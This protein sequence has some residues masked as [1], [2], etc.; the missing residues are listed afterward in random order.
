M[1]AFSH[2]LCTVRSDK[3]SRAA[4]SA[5]ENP[6]KNLHVYQFSKLRVDFGE[7]IQGI[8]DQ[9]EFFGVNPILACVGFER[10]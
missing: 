3:F 8:A 10:G 9:R 7:L 1:R 5:K 6:Q 4:I 2:L